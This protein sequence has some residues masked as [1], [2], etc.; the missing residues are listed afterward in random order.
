MILYVTVR[1][2][3]EIIVSNDFNKNPRE[4]HAGIPY[5]A[6]MQNCWQS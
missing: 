4:W 3:P 6:E 2:T 1:L 5:D